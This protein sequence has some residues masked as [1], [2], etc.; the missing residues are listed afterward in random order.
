MELHWP[1]ITARLRGRR[2]ADLY[3]DTEH[4]HLI[5]DVD[6]L[7]AYVSADRGGVHVVCAAETTSPEPERPSGDRG[8]QP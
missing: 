7:T 1:S 4:G 6:G 5:F 8:N 3:Y 2:I